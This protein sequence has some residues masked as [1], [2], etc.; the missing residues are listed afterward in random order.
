MLSFK[1]SKSANLTGLIHGITDRDKSEKGR[2]KNIAC[3]GLIYVYGT[4]G[5]KC[6]K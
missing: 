2:L 4:A 5:E 1:R 6:T 3:F